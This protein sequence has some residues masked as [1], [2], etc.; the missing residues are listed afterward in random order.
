MSFWEIAGVVLTVFFGRIL[1]SGITGTYDQSRRRKQKLEVDKI[2]AAE[3]AWR[4]RNGD[5]TQ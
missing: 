2:V 4:K 1:Y 5:Q 3:R